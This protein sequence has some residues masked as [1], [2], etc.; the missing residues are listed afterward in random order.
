[1]KTFFS[2]WW[3]VL[4]IFFS[5]VIAAIYLRYLSIWTIVQYYSYIHHPE[6]FNTET[7]AQI[8][9]TIGGTTAPFI[10][11]LA[12]FLTF[13]AFWA[14]LRANN[15]VQDQFKLQQFESQF[16][17]MIRLHK[18]NINEMKIAGYS[19]LTATTISK[20]DGNETISRTQIERSIEGR[21][22][23]VS[24]VK[25]LNACFAVCKSCGDKFNIPQGDL[26]EIA[27]RLFFFGS[28]SSLIDDHGHVD[29]IAACRVKLKE[30]RIEHKDTFGGKKEFLV[31]GQNVDLHIKYAPFTGHESRLAHYYRHLFSAVKFVV[32]KE[33]EQLFTYEKS[34]EYLKIVRAQMSNDEQIL[35]YHN[36]IS[37]LGEAWEKSQNRFL[38]RYRMLHNLPLN[39][40]RFVEAPR[41]HFRERI[42]EIKKQSKGNDPMFEWGDE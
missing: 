11:L 31:G 29:F 21:K 41:L 16:F 35:L 36:Y 33:Q 3:I 42:L 37:G 13:I 12:G 27:Y 39:R 30:I 15:Q 20:S 8:G 24:M 18:E 26:K 40:V 23:F 7:T 22:V 19:Y 6:K 17:E 32:R 5:F 4:L 10:A 1:M 14:Q 34:R 28:F 25:E 9:D 38:S 2:S